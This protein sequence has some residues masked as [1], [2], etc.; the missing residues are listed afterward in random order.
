[1]KAVHIPTASLAQ[2]TSFALVAFA[3]INVAVIP[4]LVGCDGSGAAVSAANATSQAARPL[5]AV[6]HADDVAIDAAQEVYLPRRHTIDPNATH[7]AVSTY[8]RD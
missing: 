5:T 6:A 4:L 1:M 7:G 3:I 2:K 8:E